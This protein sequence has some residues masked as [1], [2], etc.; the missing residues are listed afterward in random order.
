[1]GGQGYG[2]ISLNRNQS[3]IQPG[4]VGGTGN[5]MGLSTN[6]GRSPSEQDKSSVQYASFHGVKNHKGKKRNSITTPNNPLFDAKLGHGRASKA[7]LQSQGTAAHI[8]QQSR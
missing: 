1:M 8:M 3:V 4:M 2:V 5:V 7:Q 6:N